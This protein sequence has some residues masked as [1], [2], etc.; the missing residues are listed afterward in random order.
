MKIYAVILN[1]FFLIYL[2][3]LRFSIWD[4]QA[5]CVFNGFNV[6]PLELENRIFRVFVPPSRTWLTAASSP[7]PGSLHVAPPGRLCGSEG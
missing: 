1:T 4:I 5:V 6:N 3:F 2:F 7:A